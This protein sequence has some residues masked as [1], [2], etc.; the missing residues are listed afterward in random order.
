MTFKMDCKDER[1]V[2]MDHK[3]IQWQGL[4]LTMMNLQV[5]LL[6]SF[7]VY[8]LVAHAYNRHISLKIYSGSADK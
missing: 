7:F 6:D 8:I 5:Q 4:T 3:C 1:W 2:E